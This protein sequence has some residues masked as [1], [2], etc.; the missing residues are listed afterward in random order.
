MARCSCLTSKEMG[1][2]LPPLEARR[3]EISYRGGVSIPINEF[4]WREAMPAGPLQPAASS[5]ARNRTILKKLTDRPE[6]GRYR[7]YRYLFESAAEALVFCK[8]LTRSIPA[9]SRQTTIRGIT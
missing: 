1:C 3:P 4:H 5:R 2:F 7:F 8:H 6:K 9:I